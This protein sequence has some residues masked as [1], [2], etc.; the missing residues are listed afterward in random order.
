MVVIQES[1][2]TRLGGTLDSRN[3]DWGQSLSNQISK[4]R[5]LKRGFIMV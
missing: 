2:S 1:T 4:L 3:R 5:Y